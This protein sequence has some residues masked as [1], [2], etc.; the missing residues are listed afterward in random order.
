MSS[1]PSITSPATWLL[2][3]SRQVIASLA[4]VASLSLP[5]SAVQAL[6]DDVVQ[7]PLYTQR[8]NDVQ[9]FSDI[10]R[11]FKLLRSALLPVCH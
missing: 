1:S 6:N 9:A 4:V 8:S 11:G 2:R 5:G 10:S 7:V 3:S